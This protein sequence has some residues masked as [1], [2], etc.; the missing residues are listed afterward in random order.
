MRFEA[1]AAC[2][3]GIV[4][5]LLE[6]C[7]RGIGEWTVDF[8]TMFTDYLAGGL[9][10]VGWWA[11]YRAKTWGPLFLILAWA[12]LMGMMTGSFLDQLEGTLRNTI[13]EPHNPLVL[14]VKFLL[15]AV[16]AVSLVLSFNSARRH[17][18]AE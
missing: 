14:A 7:R 13:A 2:A 17:K 4:L 11:S 1:N 6:T 18:A 16:S 8:T 3:M 12:W 10:L 5:P 9:L 15:F